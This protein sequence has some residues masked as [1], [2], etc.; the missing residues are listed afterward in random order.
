MPYKIAFLIFYL[1][2]SVHTRFE[3]LPLPILAT[4]SLLSPSLIWPHH[5]INIFCLPVPFLP[6]FCPPRESFVCLPNPKWRQLWRPSD[7]AVKTFTKKK[8]L[9]KLVLVAL[10]SWPEKRY[11]NIN[12][13]FN[14]HHV[15][16]PDKKFLK[17]QVSFNQ[18]GV[19]PQF[20]VQILCCNLFFQR[21]Q[22]LHYSF[23]SA[24]T[25]PRPTETVVS[26]LSNFMASLL[27]SRCL[28]LTYIKWNRACCTC[29]LT[30]TLKTN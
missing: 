26:V 6:H 8:M 18:T 13:I 21:H 10:V 24:Q 28:R 14:V 20:M 30:L 15:P 12:L 25:T 5:L 11:Y 4:F 27:L 3:N 7:D 22:R 16:L 9:T 19:H 17:S 29:L 23:T 2:F 1:H